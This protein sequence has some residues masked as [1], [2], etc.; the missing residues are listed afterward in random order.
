MSNQNL[1][2]ALHES[3]RQLFQQSMSAQTAIYT[4][5]PSGLDG[6]ASY[7]ATRPGMIIPPPSL[8]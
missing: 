2:Q 3:T 8:F 1:Q 7:A 5:D 6:L 4:F